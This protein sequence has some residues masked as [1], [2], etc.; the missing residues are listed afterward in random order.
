M[1]PA[2]AMAASPAPYSA[3]VE[4]RSPAPPP[5]DMPE[6][7]AQEPELPTFAMPVPFAPAPSTETVSTMPMAMPAPAVEHVQLPQF[8]VPNTKPTVTPMGAAQLSAR[9]RLRAA[10]DMVRQPKQ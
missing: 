3:P 10:Q 4:V 9:D 2:A 5:L 1:S 8:T 6:D 7:A